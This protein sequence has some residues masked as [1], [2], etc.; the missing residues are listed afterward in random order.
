MIVVCESCHTRY[1]VPGHA[2]EP[3]GRRVRCSRCG[4]EWFQLSSEEEGEETSIDEEDASLEQF[5]EDI[6]IFHE[7]HSEVEI[8]EIP[9]AV[10]PSHEDGKG[11][12]LFTGSE[13]KAIPVGVFAGAG[14]AIFIGILILV[15]LFLLHKPVIN[16]WPWSSKLYEMAGMDVDVMGERL[17]FDQVKVV[18]SKN[19]A[20]VA[21]LKIDG[22]IINLSDSISG[23]PAI[24]AVLRD[25]AGEDR[26]QWLIQPLQKTVRPQENIEFKSVYDLSEAAEETDIL[27]EVNLRFVLK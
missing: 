16:V 6:E 22:S 25:Q 17:I 21:V 9:E 14:A 4:H 10:V 7:D 13:E 12:S 11:I 20:G 3:D 23:V 18:K 24:K 19:E 2:L 1:L 5:A 27:R 8:A 26:A 15:F